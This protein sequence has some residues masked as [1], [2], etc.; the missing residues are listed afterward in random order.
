MV[1]LATC[2]GCK[3]IGGCVRRDG[4]KASLRGTGVSSAKHRCPLRECLYDFGQP[5]L[6]TTYSGHDEEV[7]YGSVP[8]MGEFPGHFLR[9]AKSKA[10]CFIR[11]GA[12]DAGDDDIEFVAKGS[13]FVKVPL[14]RVRA[15]PVG[16]ILS[17]EKCKICGYPAAIT[18]R[19]G[20]FEDFLTNA[21]SLCA[22]KV[23]VRVEALENV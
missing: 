22:L 11:N 20:G 21:G 19:C 3:H 7:E 8:I 18:G 14:S 16:E 17:N 10:V 12:R 6:V 5:V 13:G 9:Q 23:A 15:N 4:I 1:Y 2:I